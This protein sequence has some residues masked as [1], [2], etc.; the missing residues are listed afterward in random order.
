MSVGRQ[1]D[2]R[3]IVLR[4]LVLDA[5]ISAGGGHIGPSLS[6]LEILRVL[7][8]RI[9]HHD[10]A[11]PEWPDRDRIIL[12]KGHGCVALYAV[13]AD[14]G[15]LDPAELRTLC[16]RGSILGGHPERHLVPGVEF[17]TGSLGHGL[18][19]GVGMALALRARGSPGRVFVVLGDGELGEGSVWE[20]IMSAAHHHLANMCLLIDRNGL[21]SSGRTADVLDLDPLADKLTAFGCSVQEVDGHQIDDLEAV[22][23][24]L[25]FAPN[26][27]SAVIC[28][29]TK[30]RGVSLAED[31][32][33]WHYRGSF[34]D[35]EIAAMR[36]SLEQSAE[37][38]PML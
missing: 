6:C 12:S 29:T 21:Q 9:A 22:L 34:A 26:R 8:D 23:T 11:Q 37:Q 38:K 33:E 5:L 2:N 15:Y 18:S 4:R 27:P 35:H 32:P 7:Y 20:A 16:A 28:V 19:A 36:R 17:S 13:L 1:L 25:P 31:Q 10:G 30:G 24:R 14:H 3:S